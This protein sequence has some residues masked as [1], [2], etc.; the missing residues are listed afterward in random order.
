MFN[1]FGNQK[2]HYTRYWPGKLLALFNP[3]FNKLHKQ[4]MLSAII[5]GGSLWE[6]NPFPDNRGKDASPTMG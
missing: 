2:S 3:G 6:G 1:E 5:E 4:L